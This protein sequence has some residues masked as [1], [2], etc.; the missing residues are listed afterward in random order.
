[1]GKVALEFE[2]CKLPNWESDMLC[3]HLSCHSMPSLPSLS[4]SPYA[5]LF[6]TSIVLQED[7]GHCLSAGEHF[8]RSKQHPIRFSQLAR[9]GNRHYSL[10]TAYRIFVVYGYPP[11]DPPFDWKGSRLHSPL[12]PAIPPRPLA[13][14]LI[15]AGA[16][17]IPIAP[18]DW[19]VLPA[20]T[21]FPS[22]A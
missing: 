14:L 2:G 18:K 5:K 9:L 4:A 21:P 13:S 12:I 8:R 22:L 3:H 6:V 16:R 20:G 11:A 7:L 10:C 15:S 19:R 1:M 17:K